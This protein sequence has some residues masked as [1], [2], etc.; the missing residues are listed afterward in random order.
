MNDQGC[1][2][3]PG[4]PGGGGVG[5]GCGIVGGVGVGFAGVVA[6]GV[7]GCVGGVFCGDGGGGVDDVVIL[8]VSVV[9]VVL[10]VTNDKIPHDDDCMGLSCLLKYNPWCCCV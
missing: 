6:G 2:P 1:C 7:G 10:S 5:V 3:G 9:L 8:A 4:G